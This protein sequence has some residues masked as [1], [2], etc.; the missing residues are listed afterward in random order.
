MKDQR[1]E[2]KEERQKAERKERAERT[3]KGE[4][5]DERATPHFGR[6]VAL[7]LF[8][9]LL[10]GAAATGGLMYWKLL[11]SRVYI[12]KGTISAPVITLSPAAPGTLDQLY[13]KD[14]DVVRKNMIVATIGGTPLRSKTDGVVISVS[15]TP[16][17]LATAQTPVVKMVDPSE[18]RLVGRVEEDKGLSDIKPGQQVVFTVDAFSGK[19]Y[20]GTV[21]MVS[22]TSRDSDIVFSISDK[23]EEKEFDVKIKY[24]IDQ[25][26]ELKNG[27]SAKLWVYK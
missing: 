14:G 8:A 18:F 23:R 26:P 6:T 3:E 17:Q 25:Y 16:G 21:E 10:V 4:R 22:P 1:E 5:S 7:V 20:K 9:L 15:N 27:M 2:R 11:Q 24:P 12:E 13:V 19:E